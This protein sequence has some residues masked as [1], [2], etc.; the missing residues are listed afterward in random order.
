L[1]L[2]RE[3]VAWGPT[4]E[5]LTPE[6]LLRARRLSEAWNDQAPVCHAHSPGAAS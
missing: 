2:A 6:R 3:A 4:D 1:L 5:A